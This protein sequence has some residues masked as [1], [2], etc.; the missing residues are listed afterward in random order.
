MNTL[1]EETYAELF[2]RAFDEE[3]GLVVET[4]NSRSLINILNNFKLSHGLSG[5]SLCQT[6]DPNI[7]FI[8]KQ[9]AELP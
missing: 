5:F 6:S 3:F 2:S 8:L 1:R 7:I 9:S 4:T